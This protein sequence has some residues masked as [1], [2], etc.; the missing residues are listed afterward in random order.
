MGIESVF[1]VTINCLF[2]KFKIVQKLLGRSWQIGRLPDPRSLGSP[3][4]ILAALL[5]YINM[6]GMEWMTRGFVLLSLKFDS[7]YFKIC[8]I[9]RHLTLGVWGSL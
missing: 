8:D 2:Y 4:G 1:A 7:C 3:H 5:S 9:L 6:I